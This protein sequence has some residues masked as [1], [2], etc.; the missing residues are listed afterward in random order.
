M[1]AE[2]RVSSPEPAVGGSM[3][4]GTC[5]PS[6]LNP[7]VTGIPRSRRGTAR[8]DPPGPVGRPVPPSRSPSG[9]S[10]PRLSVTRRFARSRPSS[11]AIRRAMGPERADDDRAAARREA[12]R[13]DA[14]RPYRGS[15]RGMSPRP[16]SKTSRSG[17]RP[18]T[19][20]AACPSRT[21]PVSAGIQATA[22]GR[23]CRPVDRGRGLDR[24]GT[25][26]PWLLSRSR[27]VWTTPKTRPSRILRR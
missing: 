12:R 25:Q 2:V 24:Q 6:S 7:V 17:P 27:G 14:Q 26:H 8:P 15:S 21:P 16:G 10:R 5:S 9:R 4:P 11:S 18:P 22:R 20:R 1:R 19:A 23:R 3:I 13:G